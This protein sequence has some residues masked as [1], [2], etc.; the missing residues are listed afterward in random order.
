MRSLILSLHQNGE[1]LTNNGGEVCCLGRQ[2][3]AVWLVTQENQGLED[4]TDENV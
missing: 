4:A 3:S 2:Y 1:S